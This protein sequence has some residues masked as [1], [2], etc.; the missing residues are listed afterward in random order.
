MERKK[1]NMWAVQKKAIS[2]VGARSDIHG[3]SI[4]KEEK[5]EWISE[6]N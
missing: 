5:R 1:K 4:P 6:V 3:I 2:D